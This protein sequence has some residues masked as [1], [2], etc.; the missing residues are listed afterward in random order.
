[1]ALDA[2]KWEP[3][4]PL[5]PGSSDVLASRTHAWIKG[6][7]SGPLILVVGA[8]HGNELAGLVAGRRV[9]DLLEQTSGLLNGEVLVVV[10][11]RRAMARGRRYIDR[12]LN[13]RWDASGVQ[14]LLSRREDE[15][16]R[17][18]KEQEDLLAIFEE[19]TEDQERQAIYL[20]LHSTSGEASPFACVMP[21]P[22][23][24][25]VC[26]HLDVPRV[27]DLQKYIDSPSMVWWVER[28]RAALGIEG[29]LHEDP[30]TV[31][32]L[33]RVIWEA[34][35][36]LEMIQDIPE[37]RREVG[38]VDEQLRGRTFRVVHRRGVIP[39]MSFEMEPGF[40]SFQEIRRGQA[41]ATERTGVI[42]SPCDGYIFLPRY[43]DQGDDGFFVMVAAD[44]AP[45]PTR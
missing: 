2:E 12:D 6:A 9:V 26:D 5:R 18:D 15:R 16:S 32:R 38:G 30:L 4:E 22:E 19:V 34:L 39:G 40:H 10:G 1:M 13:R 31:D 8:M 43:Q 21:T 27:L 28:G 29:G 36:G 35:S 7:R 11:N 42:R 37:E 33:E 41:L 23:N 17:E 25:V 44:D 20:D 45:A 24:Q 14:R 3:T